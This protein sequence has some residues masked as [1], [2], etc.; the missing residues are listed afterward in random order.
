MHLASWRNDRLP[1]ML[2]AVVLIANAPRERALNVFRRVADHIH[3]AGEKAMTGDV[4]LS[5]ISELPEET[6]REFLNV[7][8][9]DDLSRHVLSSLLWF[10]TLPAKK[11]WAEAIQLPAASDSEQ[12]LMRGV[13]PSLWHQ[14]QE[15]T[16]CRW[17]RL[18]AKGA[19]GKLKFPPHLAHLAKEFAEYPNQGDMRQVRPSIRSAEGGLSAM[20]D[21]LEGKSWSNLFWDECLKRSPCFSLLRNEP[22]MDTRVGST[23]QNLENVNRQLIEHAHTT[24]LGSGV[25]A[26]HDSVFGFGLYA[27]QILRELFAVGN[28]TAV[29][30][31]FALRC[32]LECYVTLAYLSQKDKSELWLSYRVFGAGQ[33]KL[34][35]LKLEELNSEKCFVDVEALRE[36]ANEDMWEEFLPINV[37]HWENSSLR[38]EAVDAGVKDVYDKYYAWTSSYQ[39]GHW[40][41][42]RETVF[43][44][45]GNPLH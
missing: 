14:S 31:R 2:W 37:G 28:A 45:C 40:G 4:R 29:T 24:R 25:E 5:A 17:M 42:I 41:S 26:K 32:L 6:R 43:E 10:E 35:S 13:A 20:D 21:E 44:T 19:A 23:I 16:D 3:V 7:I 27:L 11:S 9:E 22:G 12:I 30:G 15:A 1:E 33:A 34:S 38:R 18:I 36:I 39:H 8:V